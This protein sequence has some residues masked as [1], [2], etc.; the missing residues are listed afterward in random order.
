MAYVLSGTDI[1]SP[2]QLAESNSTMVAQN[3]TLDGSISRDYYGSNK[4]VWVL[5]YNNVMPSDY[6]TIKTIHDTYLSTNT[7]VTWEVTEANYTISQTTVHV[8][9]QER[10]FRTRGTDYISDFRLTLTE[11]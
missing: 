3:R 7:P 10:G 9:M 4:R 5:E 2:H 1:R 6:Q 11:I 8:D